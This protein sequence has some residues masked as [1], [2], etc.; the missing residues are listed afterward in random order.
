M[1]AI[2]TIKLRR[3]TT[4]NWTSGTKT[5]AEGEIGIDTTTKKLKFGG[6][7]GTTWALSSDVVVVKSETTDTI[8]GGSTGA[9]VYQSASGTTAFLSATSSTNKTLVSTGTAPSWVFPTVSTTYF[10]TTTSAQLLAVVTDATG[11]AGKLVFS[12]NPEITTPTFVSGG[13]VS[14][15]QASGSFK[16]SLTAPVA[17]GDLSVNLP[18]TA[19]TLALTTVTNSFL[20]ADGTVQGSANPYMTGTLQVGASGFSVTTAGN[21]AT[22]GTVT[23]TNA[24][25]QSTGN[26]I[27]KVN[28]STGVLSAGLVSLSDSTNVTG[29][30]PPANGGLGVNVGT[31]VLPTGTT[32]GVAGAR[33]VLRVFVQAA[34]P[35]SGNITGYTPAVGDLWFW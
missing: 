35:S 17:S 15:V 12:S 34:Q 27:I 7:G 11:S 8:L 24:A 9:V 20:K 16:T 26:A 3:D 4:S 1:P 18:T 33:S 14:F 19:G 32:S 25:L 22:S 23:F 13:G 29:N 5:L 10:A 31:A 30:L 28:P 21:L 2:T 6:T